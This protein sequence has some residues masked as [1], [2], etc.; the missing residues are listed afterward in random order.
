MYQETKESELNVTKKATASL[1][2]A[3]EKQ[4]QEIYQM[5][6][7]AIME[8]E[9]RHETAM[10]KNEDGYQT[11]L[12]EA[13]IEHEAVIKDLRESYLK[14]MPLNVYLKSISDKDYLSHISAKDYGKTVK[15]TQQPV[16]EAGCPLAS[17]PQPTYQRL[18]EV[19]RRSQYGQR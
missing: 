9:K 17:K 6:D 16:A 12:D 7:V 1:M 19:S 5:R 11:S 8:E 14:D 3:Y 2:D 15:V 13:I 10:Q 18:L 4:V